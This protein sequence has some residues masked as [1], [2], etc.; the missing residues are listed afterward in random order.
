MRSHCQ[1]KKYEQVDQCSVM[2]DHHH[3][4][5]WLYENGLGDVGRVQP[6]K[7]DQQDLATEFAARA[8]FRVHVN[9]P[10]IIKE[11]RLIHLLVDR[12]ARYLV[13]TRGHVKEDGPGGTDRSGRVNVQGRFDGLGQTT[14]GQPVAKLHGRGVVGGNGLARCAGGIARRCFLRRVEQ[15]NERVS[16][17]CAAMMVRP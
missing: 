8:A 10:Q 15:G 5:L 2:I 17:R 14:V 12:D 16:L 9:V 13:H 7:L 6:C 3:A 11:R 4:F 1:I